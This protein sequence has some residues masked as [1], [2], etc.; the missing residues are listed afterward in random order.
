MNLITRRKPTLARAYRHAG[1]ASCTHCVQTAIPAL[2]ALDSDPGFA[3]F[4]TGFFLPVTLALILISGGRLFAQEEPTE[5]ADTSQH[6]DESEENYRQRMELRDQRYQEQ[7]RVNTTYASQ[8]GE[9]KL[10]QLPPASREHIKEQ[11]RDMIIENRQWQ[12]GDELTDYPYEPSAAAQTD[13]A[14]NKLERE[15]WAEQLEKY[16]EREAAAY[17]NASAKTSASADGQQ[18]SSE[19]ASGQGDPGSKSA[20]ASGKESAA[21]SPGKDSKEQSREAYAEQSQAPPEVSTAGVSESAL[22]FLQG[23]G[24]Q[25]QQPGPQSNGESAG[26][27][28]GPQEPSASGSAGNPAAEAADAESAASAAVAAAIPGSVEIGDLAM[29][30][31]MNTE[32]DSA[33]TD[34]SSAS[35][36]SSA[37]VEVTGQQNGEESSAQDEEVEAIA[38]DLA[39]TLTIDDLNNIDTAMPQAAGAQSASISVPAT[40]PADPAEIVEPGTLKIAELEKLEGN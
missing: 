4:C 15:A 30:Q 17:A 35:P 38:E 24:G 14:L 12:P 23:L 5:E 37:A 18:D 11:L 20:G 40:E 28:A 39:G 1:K 2:P 34:A 29:L 16:Q 6:V 10:D 22:S 33:T 3:G 9:G 27:S 8:A 31:G 21:G 7:S 13:P 32:M 25:G 19:T 26:Q 36:N